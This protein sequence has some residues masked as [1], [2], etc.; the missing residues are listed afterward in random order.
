MNKR[1]ILPALLL[2]ATTGFSQTE[3]DV[4]RFSRV[5]NYGT[6]RSTAMGGAF[7]ALGG[8][9][10]SMSGNPAGVGVFRKSEVSFTPS[11]NFA[12]SKSSGRNTNNSSFQIGTL[13][14]VFSFHNE[15]SNW[16]GFNIGFN[17]TNLNNF[18]RKNNQ[19][20]GN[21]E[22]SLTDVYAAQSQGKAPEN[23][24]PYTTG[25]A[26]DAFLTYGAVDEEGVVRYHSILETDG[27]QELVNQ[28]QTTKEDGY[29]GEY[30]ISFGTNYKDKLYLGMTVGIQSVYYKMKSTYTEI[31]EENAPSGFDLFDFYD[32]Q[33]INGV[34][35]NLKFGVIYR[36]IPELRI[37]GAIHTPTWYN[38]TYSTET[39]IYSQ[40]QTPAD[41]TIGREYDNYYFPSD[42]LNIDYNMRTPW[43]AILS[44][45]TI[46]K[47]KVIV[48]FDYEYVNYKNGK[49]DD[50]DDGYNYKSE[51]DNIKALYGSAHNL[52]AGAEFRVNSILSLRGGY[53]YWS[54]PY[55]YNKTE[56]TIQSVSAGFGLNFGQFFCD[57]AYIH[58]YSKNQTRFYQYDNGSEQIYSQPVNNKYLSNEAKITLGVRF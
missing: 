50:A 44:V 12:N 37:G 24:S 36:P 9:L 21:S 56:N 6:A 34:G 51:N 3:A 53:A 23:L 43:R 33:R 57:A 27:T 52:R 58:K 32:Y 10:S 41:P 5:S 30:A 8:D 11:L 16:K 38:M 35:T 17:Y 46:L 55:K 4:L 47:Q 15:S 45:A 40:F 31:G 13:G 20:V 22:N 7:G 26:Y 42:R 28:Y 18:N 1:Y 19:F 48:S 29:Q 2:L 25:L 14:G 39:G 54:S 49:M